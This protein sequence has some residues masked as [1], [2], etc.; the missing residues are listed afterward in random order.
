MAT[1]SVQGFLKSANLLENTQD[2]QALNNLGTAPIADDISLFINNNQNVSSLTIADA[3]YNFITGL[4]TIVN[5][6]AELN[7]SRSAVFT[8]GD[9]VRITYMD[10]SVLQSD[11]FITQSDGE[12]TFGFASDFAG[13]S[14]YTFDPP[15]AGFK[16]VRSDAVVLSNLTYLGAVEDT[17]GFS[18]GLGEGASG[19]EGEGASGIDTDDTYANQFLS[20]YQYLDIAKYQADKKFVSDR[21]V[22]TDDD[23]RMEGM[24]NI[25]D[26]SDMILTEGVNSNSPG[27]YITN[28]ASPLS[29]I[30]RIRA[31]SDTSN[32]WEVTGTGVN[33]QLSTGA[34]TAQ[35]GDL[36]LNNGILIN[37]VA[38]INESGN[39]NNVTFT[40]KAK[41]KI[42]GIDYFLCLT[43]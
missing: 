23:F 31:F 25:E 21:N 15:A 9:P 5:D 12:T 6:T 7:A 35:T 20:I 34:I 22:A 37:G 2:R 41:V 40:H 30:Q 38:P 39:V 26:P 32:P 4:I 10:D 24:F 16:V 17:A 36:K 11:L 33:T 28:P 3:E 29:N 8:N 1:S 18:S 13:D 19:V 27:L 42:D 43:S 14:Q